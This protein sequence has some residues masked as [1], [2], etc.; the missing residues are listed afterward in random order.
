MYLN[1]GRCHSQLCCHFTFLLLGHDLMVWG[2]SLLVFPILRFLDH[3]LLFVGQLKRLVYANPVDSDKDLTWISVADTHMWEIPD[4]FEVNPKSLY[5][6]CQ[7]SITVVG[8]NFEK[9]LQKL[10]LSTTVSINTLSFLLYI[11]CF[12][13][14]S[15]TYSYILLYNNWYLQ[16]SVPTLLFV[17]WV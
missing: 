1:K 17:V 2:T 7:A 8:H 5:Q 13:P 12:V 4:I 11:S 3:R 6:L 10:H 9:L 15:V 14:H 16:C